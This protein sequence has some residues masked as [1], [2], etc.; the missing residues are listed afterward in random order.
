MLRYLLI[1]SLV[2]PVLLFSQTSFAT[3]ISLSDQKTCEALLWVWVSPNTCQISIKFR[4]GENG[5]IT[6]HD[7]VILEIPPSI[8]FTNSGTINN[9][10]EIQNNGI[11]NNQGTIN[12]N[13]GKITNNGSIK[14][15][16]GTIDNNLGF[17][18]NNDHI[19]VGLYG[20]LN[21]KGMIRDLGT[22][23]GGDPESIG[24]ILPPLKQ[25]YFGIPVDEIQ[26][27]EEFILVQKNDG[28]P[29]CVTSQTKSKL[30]ER[31]WTKHKN[32]ITT[33]FSFCGSDGFDSEGNLYSYNSTHHWDENK[34]EWQYI[35]PATNSINKWMGAPIYKEQKEN[36]N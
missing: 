24:N 36:E 4:S 22:I 20:T 27:D 34:C 3:G 33:H 16:G 11:I 15:N 13:Q 32:G 7:D 31:G 1:T 21:N 8:T 9:F 26:C 35:G 18:V 6:I 17:I 25:S 12:N 29:A 2:L 19:N 30:M 28:S 10:G 23:W 5:I 14:N